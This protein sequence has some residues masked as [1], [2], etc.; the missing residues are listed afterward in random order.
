M[1]AVA[2]ADGVSVPTSML[3]YTIPA[4]VWPVR[5]AAL[6]IAAFVIAAVKVAGL[7]S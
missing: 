5:I 2:M 3:A 4:T 7:L 1:M 6:A